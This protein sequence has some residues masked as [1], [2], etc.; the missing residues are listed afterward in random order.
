MKR[1]VEVEVHVEEKE[2]V[3]MKANI[4]G[5]AWNKRQNHMSGKLGANMLETRTFVASARVV[6]IQ[7]RA[8]R[9]S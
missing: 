3:K 9:V 4:A 1:K 6:I 7:R 8:H 5:R 2:S